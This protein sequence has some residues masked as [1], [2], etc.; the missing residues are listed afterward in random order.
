MRSDKDDGNGAPQSG[1][2]P[3]QIQ[4]GGASQVDVEHQTIRR[5][6]RGVLQEG[7][8]R[9]VTNRFE[10]GRAQQTAERPPETVIVVN[11]RDMNHYFFHL[12]TVGLQNA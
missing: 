1:E 5:S 11:H 10:P 7:L 8:R 6:V 4:T 9:R 2:V 12:S 3:A